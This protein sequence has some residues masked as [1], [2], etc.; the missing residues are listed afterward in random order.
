M[1][2]TYDT[3]AHLDHVQDVDEALKEAHAVGIVGVV[4]MGV[5]LAA[6]RTNLDIQQR[7]ENPKVYVALGIHPGNI[8]PEEIDET[9][10][11]IR[12][13]IKKAVAV[14]EIGLD[15]WYK[16]VRKS[17]ARKQEQRD[18]FEKQLLIAQEFNLPVVIH[19]RGAWKDC[20]EMAKRVGIKK[21]NFHWYSGP[22]DVLGK[23][24]ENGYFISA[25]PALRYSPQLQEAVKR[26]PIEQ[27]L[28]E[29]DSPVYFQEGEG[30]FGATPKHVLKTLTLYAAIKNLSEGEAAEVFNRNAQNFFNFPSP[31]P[32]PEGGARGGGN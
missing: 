18:V 8:K 11:F 4:A 13:N 24:L 32:P 1:I 2:K 31:T 21:A 16:D 9:L 30:G 5:D 22:V 20:L 28:I 14:G 17:D 3:H 19:S 12:E 26:A 25:T 23:I 29:T 15:Y 6:N 7:T 27:T 10:Q